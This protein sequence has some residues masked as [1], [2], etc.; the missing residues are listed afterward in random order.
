LKKRKWFLWLVAILILLNAGIWVAFRFLGLN[1]YLKGELLTF[2]EKQLHAKVYIGTFSFNDRQMRLGQIHVQ[3]NKKQ[4]NVRVKQIYVNYNL[5]KVLF[6]GFKLTNAVNQIMIFEPVVTYEW[7]PS[8]PKEKKNKKS[9]FPKLKNY[10]D[11]L[12]IYDGRVVIRAKDTDKWLIAESLSEIQLN[13]ANKRKTAVVLSCRTSSRGDIRVK[14]S[15]SEA[16][17]ESVEAKIVGYR[18]QSLRLKGLTDLTGVISTDIQL[19]TLRSNKRTETII[20]AN[21]ALRDATITY[22]SY[23][24]EVPYLRFQGDQTEMRVQSFAKVNQNPIRLNGLIRDLMSPKPTFSMQAQSESTD[25]ASFIPSLA[26]KVD[27]S[28][29]MTGTT[30]NPR[31]SFDATSP[32]I[33]WE[34]QEVKNLSAHGLYSDQLLSLTL[35]QLY[36]EGTELSGIGAWMQNGTLQ[37]TLNAAS[38]GEG[39]P[40]KHIEGQIIAT[41]SFR[42]QLNVSAEIKNAAYS[43]AQYAVEDV[44]LKATWQNDKIAGSGYAEGGSVKFDLSGDWKQRYV[45]IQT[46]VERFSTR[47]IF[48]QKALNGSLYPLL[49]GSIEL[50]FHDET[51]RFNT[52]MNLRDESWS[53]LYYGNLSLSGSYHTKTQAIQAQLDELCGEYRHQPIKLSLQAHGNMNEIQLNHINL[54][55]QITAEAWWK[56]RKENPFGVQVEGKDIS[57]QQLTKYLTDE[58]NKHRVDGM[59]N[60]EANYNYQDDQ[61][62]ALHLEGSQLQ[63]EDAAPLKV[64]LQASGNTEEIKIDQ[65]GVFLSNDKQIL[66]LDASV[67]LQDRKVDYVKSRIAAF[68]LSSL[69]PKLELSGTMSG[70]VSFDSQ[71]TGYLELGGLRIPPLNIALLATQLQYKHAIIDT[72][73]VRLQQT[74]DELIVKEFKA[75]GQ[76]DL[77]ASASGSL[78]YNL[79]DG[80]AYNG[81]HHLKLAMQG[82]FLRTLSN[83][84]SLFPS[85]SGDGQIALTLSMKDEG[86]SFDDGSIEINRGI[87]KID[88]QQEQ[89]TKLKVSASIKDNQLTLKQFSGTFGDG[90]INIRNE[91]HNDYQDFKI[92][93]LN[94]GRLFIKT[95]GEGLLIS[96]PSYSPP[97]TQVLASIRG[98][99]TDEAEVTGPFDDIHVA[100]LVELKNGSGMYP[101]NTENLLK[102][103]NLVRSPSSTDYP[104]EEKESSSLPLAVDVELLFTDNMRYVTYPANFVILPESFVHLIYDGY[105]WIVPE[106]HFMSESGS[107]DIFGTNF[108]VDYL[109]VIINRQQHID[110]IT[111]SFYKKASDGS[112]ITLDVTTDDKANSNLL[113]SLRFALHSDNPE[114]RTT[115]E[116][117][118]RLRYNRSMDELSSSQKQNLLQ[119]EALQLVGTN[120]SSSF[121]DPF[122]S[123][124]EN[125]IR[126]ILRVDYINITPGFVQNFVNEYISA[127]SPYKSHV[128]STQSELAQFG[129]AILLNNLSINVG[130]YITKKLFVDYVAFIQETT[131]LSQHSRLQ[132]YHDA[133][134]RL[135]LPQRL[136]LSYTFQYKPG[137]EKNAHEIMIQ[138]SFRF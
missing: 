126:K 30:E 92:G 1:S 33:Q 22:A 98:K 113:S 34:G 53:Q 137:E 93:M 63:L 28:V 117:L 135:D 80:R 76:D 74:Q 60:F 8:P 57:V 19:T 54:N 51:I 13:I 136:K 123:P 41:V 115:T 24:A 72:I 86:L 82:N 90:K 120:I 6:S 127:D 32:S 109:N 118:S 101:E 4:W 114:D 36:W 81:D 69:M 75:V 97:S 64:V 5:L 129:S 9:E 122:L 77:L 11:E 84:V 14:A 45:A 52:D 119:D 138:R 78:D 71:D 10:F 68:E 110:R 99:Y 12:S 44:N 83:F 15:L 27:L 116:I 58:P 56:N 94:L 87:L 104:A 85:A 47:S 125:R 3:D 39:V 7:G 38:L 49:S 35:H 16:G 65:T 37:T 21:G 102:L 62:V 112:L 42:P 70:E 131:D 103:I 29:V 17:L 26:G 55:D 132:I 130:K 73:Q 2:A 79:F 43:D 50:Q 133:T 111:G 100:A 61:A 23:H 18:P 88:T 89:L 108:S 124:I 20:R 67:N 66:S 106:A 128:N 121:I 59:I 25:L 107:L 40:G 95:T 46:K 91:I 31:I 96:V 48:K 134:L 105:E